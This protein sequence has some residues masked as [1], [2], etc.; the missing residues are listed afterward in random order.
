MKN[1]TWSDTEKPKYDDN[2]DGD[3]QLYE[4]V[5]GGKLSQNKTAADKFGDPSHS[6]TYPDKKTEVGNYVTPSDYEFIAADA[7][8][9]KALKA[10]DEAL[11]E[12]YSAT[13]TAKLIVKSVTINGGDGTEDA[14]G[15]GDKVKMFAAKAPTTGAVEGATYYDVVVE[16][17]KAVRINNVSTNVKSA[18]AKN[19][20]KAYVY[21]KG[22]NKKYTDK[23]IPGFDAETYVK[24]A[25]I[26]TATKSV[27]KD[28]TTTK[29]IIDSY[30]MDELVSGKV[31]A[32]DTK[33]GTATID[34][35][36]YQKATNYADDALVAGD[37]EYTL[38]DYNGYYLAADQTAAA[39][40]DVHYGVLLA[41]GNQVATFGGTPVVKVFTSE[42]KEEVI[43]YKGALPEG[44]LSGKD[45][46]QDNNAADDVMI[47]YTLNEDGVI[48]A[49]TSKANTNV[50][51]DNAKVGTNNVLAGKFVTED[52]VVFLNEAEEPAQTEPPTPKA[53]K[54]AIYGLSDLA[55]A[56]AVKG[57]FFTNTD[58]DTYTAILLTAPLQAPEKT[59][60]I[61]GFV[62]S[63]QEK[64]VSGGKYVYTV[65]ALANGEEVTYTSVEKDSQ[66]TTWAPATTTKPTLVEF[67]LDGDKKLTSITPV[68]ITKTVA[69]L[70]KSDFTDTDMIAQFAIP[71]SDVTKVQAVLNKALDMQGNKNFQVVD[72]AYVYEIVYD[73]TAKTYTVELSDVDS[74][75]ASNEVIDVTADLYQTVKGTDH[76]NI[77]VYQ[78]T[79]KN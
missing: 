15:T 62:T 55:E 66:Q 45:E 75:Q 73:S 76:W 37:N 47:Q 69:D 21:L 40:E 9:A 71:D 53:S 48:K 64:S 14:I 25:V 70:A 32:I 46:F 78:V 38:Y 65:E 35:K 33:T 23:E 2:G 56:S 42:G 39:P 51:G 63:V 49:M 30:V 77:V 50:F 57:N 10:Y 3:K 24:D 58:G 31:S 4:D 54:Y 43:E 59:E 27:T 68:D 6:W 74:I 29:T 1:Q 52:T 34:A 41:S 18:D 44:K 11:A 20:V 36:D 60:S 17:Y 16:Q 22:D 79:E 13:P 8:F 67:K 7:T 12:D 61:L 28:S 26:A 19:G 72:G 5:F